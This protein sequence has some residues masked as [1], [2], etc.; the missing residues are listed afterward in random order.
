MVVDEMNS[1]RY[2]LEDDP[3]AGIYD[4][5]WLPATDATRLREEHDM[6]DDSI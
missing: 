5:A 6:T 4:V 1:G 2:Q 3:H